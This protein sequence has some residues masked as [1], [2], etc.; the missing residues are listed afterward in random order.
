MEQEGRREERGEK[1]EHTLD[2]STSER[3]M[4]NEVPEVV[5]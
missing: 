1:G 5:R 3:G 2:K 4:G